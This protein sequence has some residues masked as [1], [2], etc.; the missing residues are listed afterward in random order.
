MKPKVHY[1]TGEQRTACSASQR[2]GVVTQL[3][4]AVDAP[5]TV[6]V[7]TDR[8]RVTCRAC[9][10]QLRRHP[11]LVRGWDPGPLV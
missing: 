11:E 7:T 9:R 3:T 5:H 4:V 1:Y 10:A 8:K 6:K 2:P